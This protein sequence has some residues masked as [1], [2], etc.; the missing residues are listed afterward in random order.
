VRG[1]SFGMIKLY[2]ILLLFIS[3]TINIPSSPEIDTVLFTSSS[4]VY[5]IDATVGSVNLNTSSISF[6]YSFEAPIISDFT[7]DS[8]TFTRIDV[9]NLKT[10][11]KYNTPQLPYKSIQ[12][13]LPPNTNV[14]SINVH[15]DNNI[16]SINHLIIPNSP[17]ISSGFFNQFEFYRSA[18]SIY[19]NIECYPSSSVENI[20]IQY[21]R[22][23]AILL[24][25]LY[26]IQYYPSNNEL[27]CSSQIDI[28]INLISSEQDNSLYRQLPTDEVLIKNK[29]ENPGMISAYSQ[30]LN[31][32]ISSIDNYQYV[33]ITRSDLEPY[34]ETFIRYKQDYITAKIVNLTYI[35]SFFSGN[36]YQE[37]IRDF[38]KYAYL[39]WGTDYVLL[40]GDINVIPYRGLWGHAIDHMGEVLHDENIPADI[41]FAGLD[42]TWDADGDN[43]FGENSSNS[44][45]EEADFFAEVFVGRAPVE[46]SVE[47]GTF[48]NKVITYETSTKP[49]RIQLHQSGINTQ[50]VPDS[51]IIPEKCSQ[52]IPE[53]YQVD[54]LYQVNEI[55]TPSVWMDSF[56]NDALIIQH[57]GNG[58]ENKYYLNWPTNAFT[59]SEAS[60]LENDFY[61]IHTSVACN[62]GSFEKDDCIAETLLLNPYGGPSACLFNSRKG[63]TSNIDAHAYSGEFIESQFYEIFVKNI[64]EIG[65]VNQY[66]KEFFASDAYTDNAYRWCY[67]TINLLGDPEMPVRETREDYLNSSFLY[68]NKSY[69]SNTAGWGITQF[70]SIQSA[71]DA[72]SDWDTIYVH[73]GIYNEDII[74]RKTINLVGE[75]KTSTIIEGKSSSST[76]LISGNRVKVTGF[77]IK[78][79]KYSQG[80][81][82]FLLSNSNYIS[83]SNCIISQGSIG[84]YSLASKNVFLVDNDF[85]TNQKGIFADIN[86]NN[87]YITKNSFLID[88]PF[89]YGL[90]LLANANYVIENN[91][92]ISN[93]DF[94]NFT[95]GILA[96]GISTIKYNTITNCHI[97]IW[98]TNGTHQILENT[99]TNNNFIGIYVQSSTFTVKDNIVSENGNYFINSNLYGYTL[100]PGGIIINGSRGGTSE[101]C[102]NVIDKNK[103]YGLFFDNHFSLPT[104]VHDNDFLNNAINAFFK[105]SHCS[106]FNNY[107]GRTRILPK[108]IVGYY[109]MQF[110]LVVPFI[111]VDF[112]PST[113]L[114]NN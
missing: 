88:V 49:S 10:I 33:L 58:V 101:V 89:G 24:L 64:E 35:Y 73:K 4:D 6:S 84:V 32:T 100:K 28:T 83:I 57:T 36:D 113:T 59:T 20:G 40:G 44:N 5:S 93:Q 54:K 105:N 52:W 110:G 78:N 34:F 108:L 99:V 70:N 22:G 106:W 21:F 76:I 82:R 46:N 90:A 107:W 69:Q 23:Y 31:P 37:K 65:R 91:S 103:G 38:I 13:L 104:K 18:E 75:N 95:Y 47:V 53:N 41:Y 85:T 81:Y 45:Q 77:T 86:S 96:D 60:I 55:I 1:R 50:N 67:Y 29:V 11:R 7:M 2:L 94:Y 8:Y 16:L 26:P 112:F 19:Q 61:P 48:I 14:D 9:N 17:S 25:N 39:N 98:V 66:A 43:I 80:S 71:I 87:L 62:S 109:K 97:G 92:I 63:F 102:H 111:Q 15:E 3:F 30:H 42:G 114:L 27:L 56:T 12:V 79:E 51:S 68:V 74:I 72:S